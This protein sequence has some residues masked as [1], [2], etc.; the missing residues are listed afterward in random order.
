LSVPV[1]AAFPVTVN[2]IREVRTVPSD[3]VPVTTM[4]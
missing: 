3:P 4:V 1:Q 2:V